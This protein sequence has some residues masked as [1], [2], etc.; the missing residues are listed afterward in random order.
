MEMGKERDCPE[1]ETE[2]MGG[3][4]TSCMDPSHSGH[5]LHLS[6]LMIFAM[7]STLVSRT[8]GLAESCD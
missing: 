6:V 1:A 3:R 4:R 7:G 5:L 8:R 2:Q